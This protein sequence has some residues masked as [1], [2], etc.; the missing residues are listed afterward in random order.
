MSKTIRE[1]L[2][3]ALKIRKYTA[4]ELSRQFKITENDVVAYIDYM[5]ISG[6]TDLSIEQA[7][8]HGCGFDFSNRNNLRAPKKCP[9]CKSLFVDAPKFSLMLP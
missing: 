2:I 7:V 6:E 8:C 1:K 4:G 9:K 5:R 3:D